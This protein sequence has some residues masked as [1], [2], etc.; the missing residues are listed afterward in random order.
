MASR[1]RQRELPGLDDKAATQPLKD[2]G[3]P[4]RASVAESA[5]PSGA[6]DD[7]PLEEGQHV[8]AVSAVATGPDQP[9]IDPSGWQVYVVDA[10]SLIFQVFHALPGMTSPRGEQVAAVY[11]FVRDMLYL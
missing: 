5:R 3:A 6:R 8:T 10:Y 7:L 1:S 9:T 4:R 2:R 11:G